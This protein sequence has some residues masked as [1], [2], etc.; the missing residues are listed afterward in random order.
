MSVTY[1][2]MANN[3]TNKHQWIVLDGDIDAE[4]IEV[5]SYKFP[6]VFPVQSPVIK[7]GKNSTRLAGFN[8]HRQGYPHWHSET[9]HKFAKR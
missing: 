1:R 6:A 4:W 5:S 8:S 7:N 2:D 3:R 9:V